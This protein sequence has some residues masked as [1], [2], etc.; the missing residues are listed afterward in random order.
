VKGPE[1]KR[2]VL[3]IDDD[4]MQLGLFMKMLGSIYDLRTAESASLA[5]H[6]LETER[7][8]L[9]LLDITM[10]HIS[11]FD[12]LSDIKRNPGY[13]KVPIIIVSGN[14]GDDFMKEAKNSSAYDVLGKPVKP[15]TLIRTIEKALNSCKQQED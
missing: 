13:M 10:P 12:F 7:A 14:S 1:E 15:D 2:I 5:K 8:D 6:Y 9:I 3:A 4:K 11:G